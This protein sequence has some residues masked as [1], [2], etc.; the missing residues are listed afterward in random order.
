M[1]IS[2]FGLGYVGCVTSGCFAKDGHTVIGVDVMSSKVERFA[3]GKPTVVES[4]LD[5]LMAEAHRFGRVA[6][7]CD[8]EAAV[9]ATDVSVICVGTPNR[10]DGSADLTAVRQTAETIGRALRAKRGKHVV[11]LRSTVP[12]GTAESLVWPAL[13]AE[14]GRTAEELGLVM[15]P[16]FLREGS[17][18]ADYYDPPFVVVGSCSGGADDNTQVVNELFGGLASRVTWMTFGQ[19]EMLK[20][21]CNAFHALKVAFGNEVGALCDVLSIDGR[22]LMSCFVEDTKLNVSA[23]YLRPGLPFGGSCLPKDL[24]AL[25]HLGSSRGVDIPLLRSVLPSNDAQ[26]RRAID[27]I[28]K[29]GRCRVGLDRLAFKSGTDDLRESPAVA[30]AEYLIGKGYDLKIFDPAVEA[31]RLTGANREY[32]ERHVPHLSDRLVRNP[33]ELMEHAQILVLTGDDDFLHSEARAEWDPII[34]DLTGAGRDR[35]TGPQ[36]RVPATDS[37]ALQ[38]RGDVCAV[39]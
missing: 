35:N 25:L 28:E 5:E 22:N 23:A 12:P 18:I 21:V 24:R 34:V 3:S 9:R 1:E 16:E 39:A 29:H 4:G 15:V 32:I 8:A 11:M 30:I 19:A 38:V 27:A 13:L 20:T 17:A 10:R 14:S 33:E 37:S 36:H 7:T 26:T 31:A 6:A 2:V